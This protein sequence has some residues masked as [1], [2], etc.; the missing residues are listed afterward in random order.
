MKLSHLCRA[1]LMVPKDICSTR[2]I[3]SRPREEEPGSFHNLPVYA[4]RGLG[5]GLF[6]CSGSA[7]AWPF[8]DA[9]ADV[10]TTHRA[11]DIR[12][13]LCRRGLAL[14]PTAHAFILRDRRRILDIL[15]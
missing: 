2:P 13:S 12:C 7:D 10:D 8:G 15:H 11:G 9:V 4:E 5:R 3:V 14:A 1:P 6:L